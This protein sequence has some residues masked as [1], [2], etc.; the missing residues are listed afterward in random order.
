MTT[1][2][3]RRGR[4]PGLSVPSDV[5]A[6]GEKWPLRRTFAFVVLVCGGFWLA[7]GGAVWWLMQALG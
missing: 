3:A 2:A 1:I 4:G 6:S 7:V 5:C